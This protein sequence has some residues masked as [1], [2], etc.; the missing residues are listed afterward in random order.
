MTWRKLWPFATPSDVKDI[1]LSLKSV[2][3][4]IEGIQSSV[5]QHAVAAE[6]LLRNEEIIA[7]L[8]TRVAEL[9][10]EKIVNQER[11]LKAEKAAMAL[12]RWIHVT[13]RLDSKIIP[14]TIKQLIQATRK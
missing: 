13:H 4:K 7:N 14:G 12:E 5:V 10:S 2:L 11:M 6:V 3:E 8:K 1:Q 9:E